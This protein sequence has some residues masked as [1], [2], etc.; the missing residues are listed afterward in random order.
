MRIIGSV[1]ECSAVRICEQTRSGSKSPSVMETMA[2][3]YSPAETAS[4]A[5]AGLER[6]ST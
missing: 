6:I 4:T 5:S 3:S 1:R 2:R